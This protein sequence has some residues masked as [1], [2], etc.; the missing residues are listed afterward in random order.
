MK[1]KI[2]LVCIAITIIASSCAT[3]KKCD[4]YSNIESK[5]NEADV[6]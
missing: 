6:S 5:N 2:I 1:I 4:A 3:H